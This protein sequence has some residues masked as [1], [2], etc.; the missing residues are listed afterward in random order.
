M[1]FQIVTIWKTHG[2]CLFIQCLQVSDMPLQPELA[3]QVKIGYPTQVKI[4]A[5]LSLNHTLLQSKF[6]N[7]FSYKTC[8]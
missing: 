8:E 1:G 4:G 6:S 2:I 5:Q 7:T 3:T